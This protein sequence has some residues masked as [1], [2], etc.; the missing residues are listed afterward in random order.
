MFK[1]V[2]VPTETVVFNCCT[3]EL[4]GCLAGCT[5]TNRADVVDLDDSV[6]IDVDEHSFKLDIVVDAVGVVI[7]TADIVF[8]ADTDDDVAAIEVVA[9]DLVATIE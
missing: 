4:L 5:G 8:E 9:D 1:N 3:V 7:A 2:C 6:K